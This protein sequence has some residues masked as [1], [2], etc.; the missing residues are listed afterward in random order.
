MAK[1]DIPNFKLEGFPDEFFEE[2]QD[3]C[4][5][6]LCGSDKQAEEH[7]AQGATITDEWTAGLED[8]FK[9]RWMG[10]AAVIAAPVAAVGS[11]F[12]AYE[13]YKTSVEPGPSYYDGLVETQLGVAGS[14]AITAGLIAYFGF[15]KTRESKKIEAELQ[16]KFTRKIV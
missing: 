15:Q 10:I 12:F 13:A 14:F 7:R 9:A 1:S 4:Y 6:D 3:Y 11:A 8:R 5:Q 2:L 16:E